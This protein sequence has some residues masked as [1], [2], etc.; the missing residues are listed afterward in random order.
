[1]LNNLANNILR[2]NPLRYF[3]GNTPSSAIQYAKLLKH[4]SIYNY[5]IEAN[6]SISPNDMF[7]R[8]QNLIKEVN[9]YEEYKSLPITTNN[10][11]HRI[12]L[13][14][15]SFNF[16]KEYINATVKLFLHNN[17]QVIID[18]ENNVNHSKYQ[19]LTNNLISEYNQ[20]QT[21]IIKTYQMYRKDTYV[22]LWNDLERYN[23]IYLGVKLVRGAYWK[24]DAKS[25]NLF[26]TKEETDENFN[27][28]LIYLY[29]HNRKSNNI[30]ATHNK[31]SINILNNLVN[32]NNLENTTESQ[33]N[34]H[35]EYAYLLGLLDENDVN[36]SVSQLISKYVYLPYGEYRYMLPYLVRRYI[37]VMM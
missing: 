25:G 4:Q 1:M 27:N 30:I 20:S 33:N 11:R 19:T 29:T 32:S 16:D 3:G 7:M 35:M 24:E 14:L 2:L 12:A 21:N 15:S 34:S 10:Q 22:E 37:E 17:W 9:G 28:A 31:I 13:K 23:K 26:T 6:K 36:A 5:F 18:A 8:Y